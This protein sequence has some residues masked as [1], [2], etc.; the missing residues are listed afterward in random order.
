MGTPK[1]VKNRLHLDVNASGGLKVPLDERRKQV[2]A[3][4]ERLV[5]LGAKRDHELDEG[6][7]KYCVIMLDP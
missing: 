4:V 3:E 7:R 2:D 1:L 6:R 5:R